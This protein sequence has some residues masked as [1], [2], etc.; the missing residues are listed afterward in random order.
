MNKVQNFGNM[1]RFISHTINQLRGEC[2]HKCAYCSCEKLFRYPV[3]REK[4]SGMPSLDKKAVNENLGEGNFIFM[5]AQSDLFAEGVSDEIKTAV[6]KQAN[7]YDNNYL[8]QTKNP[9][10][11]IKFEYLMPFKSTVCITLESN[12]W[13]PKFMGNTPNPVDRVLSFFKL[14]RFAK[15]I[16]VEPIMAFDLKEFASLIRLIN[17]ISVNIG[18][19]TNPKVKLPE[20]SKEEILDLIAE[21]E[22]FTKV[23]KKENLQRLLK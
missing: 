13:Y 7:K 8:W 11:M 14:V 12:R 15:M 10:G 5:V 22:T 18:A 6:I 9:E 3:I 2:L 20:P 17:P 19:N 21:L 16:T 1:Y 23:N 4:Y